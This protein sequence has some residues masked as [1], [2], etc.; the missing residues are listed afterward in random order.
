MLKSFRS[1]CNEHWVINLIL[2]IFF[3]NVVG[4]LYRLGGKETSSKVVG[5]IQ[6]ALFILGAVFSVSAG[7]LGFLFWILEIV[8]IVTV[9][10]NKKH[11]ISVLAD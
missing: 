4:G 2:L 1:F 9:I 11:N 3:G 7:A 5:A 6:L 8:D 10:I